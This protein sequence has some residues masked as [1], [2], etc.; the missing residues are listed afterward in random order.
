MI[1]S[2]VGVRLMTYDLADG[3]GS[4]G[5]VSWEESLDAVGDEVVR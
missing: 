1:F 2:G 4:N 5:L 3:N